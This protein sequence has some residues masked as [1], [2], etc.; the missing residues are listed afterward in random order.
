MN[1]YTFV[2]LSIFNLF[3]I[4]KMSCPKTGERNCRCKQKRLALGLALGLLLV[5]LAAAA[6]LVMG[7]ARN[8]GKP[9]RT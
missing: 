8:K 6:V 7:P 4:L 2:F 1:L 5:A 3:Y 9:S